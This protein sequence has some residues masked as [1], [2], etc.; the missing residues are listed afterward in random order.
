MYIMVKRVLQD[1]HVLSNIDTYHKSGMVMLNVYQNVMVTRAA[2]TSLHAEFELDCEDDL[3]QE[4]S[5]EKEISQ[6]QHY[7]KLGSQVQE[8]EDKSTTGF[9]MEDNFV[10]LQNEDQDHTITSVHKDDNVDGKQKG[11][12]KQKAN[13]K[14]SILMWCP[15]LHL[16]Q[17]D[18]HALIHN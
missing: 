13:R 6:K 16:D 7:C 3:M 15:D 8:N 5:D 4:Q 14:P 11:Q 18:R 2:Q 12:V 10:S 17:E 9:E 1:V